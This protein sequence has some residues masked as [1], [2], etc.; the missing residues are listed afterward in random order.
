MSQEFKYFAFISYNSKDVK[1]GSRLQR[2]LEGYRMSATLCSEK[3]WSRRPLKPIFF[4]PTDIQPNDLTEELKARLRASRHL[5][6]VCSPNSAQSEWVGK[7]I[8]YFHSLGRK[9]DIHFFIVDGVPN[10]NDPATECFNPVIKSLGLDGVLG[11]NINE[12]N[13]SWRYLNRQRAY[14]Q[15]ITKLLGIEFDTIWKRHKRQL[16]RMWAAYIIALIAVVATV[17]W[18]WSAHRPI[19]VNVAL[20]E[21]SP[22]NNNL[23]QL[24]DAEVT[25][26]LKDDVRRIR[27]HS[28]D[29]VAQFTNIPKNLLGGEATLQFEDF[30][31]APECRDYLP[32]EVSVTLTEE[33]RLPIFRDTVKY[34]LLRARVLN[35][36]N[37]PMSN[38]TLEIAGMTI[39]TNER[40]YIDTLIP[41]ANQCQSYVVMGDTLKNIGLTSRYVIYGER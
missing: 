23:P 29:E 7:E 28:I 17:T 35:S 6:V 4:A 13:Y 37:R 9:S 1:W 30:P 32:T 10:S 11:A 19:T 20:E 14:V 33:I 18:S 15:L 3:G 26:I 38:Y 39:T 27:L 22:A 2:K 8:A 16:I 31:D 12:R 24:S 41:F 25:L 21:R 5:I 36:E 34:G 40:G